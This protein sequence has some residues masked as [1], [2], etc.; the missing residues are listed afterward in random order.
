MTPVM[1]GT[2]IAG[3]A[4]A[5]ISLEPEGANGVTVLAEVVAFADLVAEAELKV[6]RRGAAGEIVSSQTRTVSVHAGDRAVIAKLN[7]S[8]AVGDELTISATVSERGTVIS[9]ATVSTGTG[10]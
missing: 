6:V 9:T 4:L 2:A 5:Q 1:S 10:S 7:L 8:F 3:A